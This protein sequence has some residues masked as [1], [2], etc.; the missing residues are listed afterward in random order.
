M[1]TWKI[2]SRNMGATF[3][4]SA[5]DRRDDTE[6]KFLR[7]LIKEESHL[8]AKGGRLEHLRTS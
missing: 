8:A 5:P 1:I 6:Q 3:V 4:L 7:N 2:R